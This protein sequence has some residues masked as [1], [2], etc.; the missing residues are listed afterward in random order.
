MLSDWETG[1]GPA[2]DLNPQRVGP[3]LGLSRRRLP[4]IDTA[5]D[6]F[7]VSPSWA[8]AAAVIW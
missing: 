2:F 7:Q 5:T 6:C 8:N 4:A 3:T 1:A